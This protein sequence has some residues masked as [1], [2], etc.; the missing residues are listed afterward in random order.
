[1]ANL[2]RSIEISEKVTNI[3][4]IERHITLNGA[5]DKL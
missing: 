2:T 4:G 1:M 5:K 3:P